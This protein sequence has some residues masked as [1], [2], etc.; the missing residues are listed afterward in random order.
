MGA[1]YSAASSLPDSSC[2]GESDPA[3]SGSA[4]HY[5]DSTGLGSTDLDW[6]PELS[7]GLF[8]ERWTLA[9]HFPAPA[10]LHLVGV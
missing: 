2:R 5:S 8:P 9:A 4:P 3:D 10:Q 7:L 1:P 6:T